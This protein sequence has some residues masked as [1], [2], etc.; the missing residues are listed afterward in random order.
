MKVIDAN[1]SPYNILISSSK[2]EQD[3][4]VN[5]VVGNLIANDEDY[6]ETFTFQL[7]KGQ[8]DNDNEYFWI[9]RN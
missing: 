9:D 7:V 1:D 2:V 8:S 3:A 4:A 6:Q 5:T